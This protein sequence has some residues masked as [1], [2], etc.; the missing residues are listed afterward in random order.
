MQ[1]RREQQR[2]QGTLGRGA[3]CSVKE[4]RAQSLRAQQ[5]LQQVLESAWYEYTDMQAKGDEFEEAISKLAQML[6]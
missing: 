6:P 2:Q 4:T 1:W 5:E 3:A